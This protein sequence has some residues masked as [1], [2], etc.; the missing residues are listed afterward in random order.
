MSLPACRFFRQDV[1]RERMMSHDF[2]G[3]CYFEAL[4]GATMCFQFHW[5]FFFS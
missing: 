4:R 5:N 2:S 1:P 3:A